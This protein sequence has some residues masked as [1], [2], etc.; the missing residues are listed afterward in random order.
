MTR[1]QLQP[2]AICTARTDAVRYSQGVHDDDVDGRAGG[3]GQPLVERARVARF[4]RHP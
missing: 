2:N 3:I 4:M 1:L